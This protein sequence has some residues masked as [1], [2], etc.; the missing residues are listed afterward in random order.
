[1]A[2]K[3]RRESFPVQLRP[4]LPEDAGA[5]GNS[6]KTL[7][8]KGKRW[9]FVWNNYPE[10]TAA[11][12]VKNFL[13]DRRAVCFIFGKE[14]GDLGT[15]HLQGYVEFKS[16]RRFSTLSK[17]KCHWEKARQTKQVNVDYCAKENDYYAYNCHPTEKLD[18]PLEFVVKYQWQQDAE[19]MCLK[20]AIPHSR[21]IYFFVGREGGEGKT[22]WAKSMCIRFHESHG[23]LY[24]CGPAKDMKYAIAAMMKEGK[25]APK[26]VILGL[27]RAQNPEAVSYSGLEQI[28]DGIFFSTKYESSMV[29][30][31]TPHVIVLSNAEPTY[32]KLSKDRFKVWDLNLLIAIEE[33]IWRERQNKSPIPPL[34]SRSM[35]MQEPDIINLIESAAK[36]RKEKEEKKIDLM[37]DEEDEGVVEGPDDQGSIPAWMFDDDLCMDD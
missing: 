25:R 19:E 37:D 31:N 36:I 24:V 5:R 18:D 28:K 6:C 7:D 29:M 16:D 3:S 20:R 9:I 2:Q 11:I 33:N 14:T 12:A 8:P 1:M 34:V 27:P 23:C 26:I 15:R 35:A 22:S 30:Y 4:S 13:R 17:L 21:E 10:K 32:E